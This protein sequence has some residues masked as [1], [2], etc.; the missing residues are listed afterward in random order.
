MEIA[1]ETLSYNDLKS[2]NT[3]DN[4]LGFGQVF[5]DRMF[6]VN[7]NN[8]EWKNAR[9]VKFENI[10]LNPAAVCLHYAQAIF[11]GQKAYRTPQGYLNLFRLDKNIERFNRSARRLVMPEIDPELYRTGLKTLLK[12]EKAWAP[13][14]LGSSLYIRPTMIGT[15]SMLGLK[16]AVDFLF[17]IILS[18]SGPFFPE[19]F[20]CVN[21]FVSEDYIRAAPGGTGDIKTGGNYAASLFVTHEAIKNG[22]SQVLWLDAISKKYIEEVGAMNIFFV[23]DDEIY[24]PPIKAGTILSG[25][26]RDSVIILANDNGFSVTE[27]A[28]NIDDIVEAILEGSLTECFG[29]GTA[30]SLAPIGSLYFRNQSYKINDSVVGPISQFLYREL[31]DIQYGRKEDPYGWIETI[32]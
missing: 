16:A 8:D 25:V 29:T 30:A 9:I 1:I 32:G 26:T 22:F 5:T 15:T 20:K 21:I 23:I 11:E 10:S 31:I 17:Y 19:G 3:S 4:D 13:K 6:V 14:K 12:L 27:K 18:P 28:L 2:K 24:T 7:Y